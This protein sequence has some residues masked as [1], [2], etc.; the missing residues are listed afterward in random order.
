MAD[1]RIFEANVTLAGSLVAGF[2]D[3]DTHKKGNMQ[4]GIEGVGE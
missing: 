2:G 3:E 4:V 1:I